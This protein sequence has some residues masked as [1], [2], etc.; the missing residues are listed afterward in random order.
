MQV[1][2][3]YSD[4]CNKYNSHFRAEPFQA[5]ELQKSFFEQEAKYEQFQLFNE[6]VAT[7]PNDIHQVFSKEC[8]RLSNK[9]E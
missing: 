6:V 1:K 8:E 7:L 9:Q 5:D 4:A 2:Q 3:D